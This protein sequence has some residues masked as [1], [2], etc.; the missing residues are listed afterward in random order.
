MKKLALSLCLLS[1]G[2]AHASEVVVLETL[3]FFTNGKA[4]ARFEVNKEL[5]RAWVVMDITDHRSGPRRE[6]R[7]REIREL[8][9]GLSYDANSRT[10][11]YDND[12]AIHD[13]AKVVSRGRSIFRYDKITPLNCSLKVKK[14]RKQVDDGFRIRHQ[15]VMQ[16]VL[17][18]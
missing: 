14:V 4:E 15:S 7:T 12:G 17:T 18:Y 1:F 3:D 10:I 13:C 11:V 16:A 5:G 8:V 6:Q 9:P 2:A